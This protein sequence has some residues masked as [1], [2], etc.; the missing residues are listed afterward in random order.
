MTPAA[1]L[2]CLAAA[3]AAPAAFA[4]P[5]PIHF[6]HAP[7]PFTLENGE[8]GKTFIPETMAG[9]LAVF[10]YD[11]DGDLD[12][13]FTNGAPLPGLRKTSPEHWNRLFANDGR[14]RF[15][16]VTEEAGLEGSC[17]DTA[18][19]V[20][21][22]DNDGDKDL[23]VGG[24]HCYTFYRNNGDGTFTDI[25]REAGLSAE[26]PEFGPLWAIGGVWADF[27]NDG[28]LDLFVVNYLRWAPE[29][30]K[31]CPGY[32]HPKYYPATPNRLY[33]N[34][35]DG[36]FTDVSEAS[37]IRAHPGKGMGGAA[38]DYDGDGDLDVFVTNDKMFNFLFENLGRLRFREVAFE[39]GVA[40][41]EHA[42]EISGMGA[43]FR[44]FDNDGRPDIVFVALDGETFPLFCNAGGGLFEEITNRSGL[45]F[46][47]NSMAGY[48]PGLFDFDNDGWKDLF[49]SRGHVQSPDMRGQWTIEQHN[50]VFRNLANGRFQALTGEA[51]FTA[52]PPKRH[53]GAGF[54]D[55]NGDGLIDVVVSALK[56]PAEIWINESPG[57][58]HW[59]EL[60]LVGT[61]SNR[62]AVGAVVKVVTSAG[63]QYNHV[64]TSMGYGSAS[65]G[66]LHFGLGPA[67]TADLVE[68]RWPSGRLQRLRSVRADR[69]LRVE[70]PAA[71][72]E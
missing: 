30:E 43:D 51:G 39:A 64:A 72:D 45:A 17:Y 68:I 37:G 55:F 63:T 27:D 69:V 40:L 1:S 12:V 3:L 13:F 47:S 35:G 14:G 9:G 49:V 60:D 33:R 38:A 46:Q 15:T 42:M 52:E 26:D 34:N 19:A 48:G 57:G 32:C 31:P 25:T 67:E 23:F 29:L 5:G 21:D 20:A 65:A 6:R 11:N 16:D 54:G 56:A 50:T 7:I 41:A 58:D 59:L 44:D 2:L 18:A 66:P 4:Q 70:E 22:Y 36:T 24:V 62:D 61:K 28:W 8:Q 71:A 10:D 53:R